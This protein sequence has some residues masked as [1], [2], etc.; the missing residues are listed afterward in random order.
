MAGADRRA[1][2]LALLGAYGPGVE[3]LCAACVAHLPGIS[4][5]GLAIMTNLPASDTRY[6]SD[7]TSTRIE[8]LQFTLGEGP[9]VDA[10]NAGRPVIVPDLAGRECLLRWPAFTVAAVAAGARAL[11]AFPLQ[12]G[13]IRI[14][15]LDLYRDRVGGLDKEEL[16]DALVF[17]DIVTL[18][19]LAE[20]HTEGADWRAYADH[21]QRAVVHQAT[22][23]VMAQ[24][25]G[26]IEAAF[27]RLRAYAYA[28]DR[29][30][31]VIAD[32][33]VNRRLRFDQLKD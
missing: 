14:G 5:A 33:V 28:G 17:A 13:A 11:F 25:G 15:V 7:E 10:F 27:D 9:C 24:L 3:S 22:G 26:T 4:G 16:A 29:Q 6:V 30:L 18:L 32:D 12:M 2:V 8:D 21:D 20:D 23:M 1:R 19:L 31:H